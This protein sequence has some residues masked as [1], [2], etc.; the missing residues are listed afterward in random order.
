MERTVLTLSVA[1]FVTV[2]L[3]VALMLV[4]IIVVTRFMRGRADA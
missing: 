2:N 3:M 1:N 4:A